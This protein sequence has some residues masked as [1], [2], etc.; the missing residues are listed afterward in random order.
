MQCSVRRTNQA[1]LKHKVCCP[2]CEWRI[3]LA[4]A[5]VLGD[6]SVKS[7]PSSTGRLPV[8]PCHMHWLEGPC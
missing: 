5:A 4:E 2:G 8:F 1:V 7:I 3:D 6:Y